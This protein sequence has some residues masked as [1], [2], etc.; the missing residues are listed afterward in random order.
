[1]RWSSAKLANVPSMSSEFEKPACKSSPTSPVPRSSTHVACPL[2]GTYS[3]TFTSFVVADA[4]RMTR[5]VEHDAQLSR[6][7]IGRLVRC[8]T[9]AGRN[10]RRDRGIHVVDL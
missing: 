6:I 1:M 7:A 9:S 8:D 4:E 5:G 2:I 10:H 3:P